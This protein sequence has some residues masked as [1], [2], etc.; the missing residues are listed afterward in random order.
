MQNYMKI[1]L[2]KIVKCLV[3]L[4]VLVNINILNEDKVSAE[5]SDINEVQLY[6]MYH[7]N[8]GDTLYLI[9]QKFDT[10][11]EEL[12]RVNH[13]K[14]SLLMVGQPLKIPNEKGRYYLVQPNDTLYLIAG[15][16]NLSVSQLKLVNKLTSNNIFVGQ[17][18]YIPDRETVAIIN[19][20]PIGLYKNGADNRNIQLVQQALNHYGYALSEDGIYGWRTT[21]AI[22]DFQSQ[23]GTLVN[24]GVYGPNTKKVLQQEILTDKYIVSNPNDTLVLVNKEYG[25]PK[26]YV[27]NNLVVP[28]VKFLFNEYHPKKL[29]RKVAAD[30][31]E[32]LF[33]QAQREGIQLFAV[34]GYRSFERQHWIFSSKAMD[35]GMWQANTLSAKAGESEHQ[36]GLT[37][38]VTSESAN[39]QLTQGFGGTREGKWLEKN[40]A[41]FGFIIHYL[42]GKEH[43]TGYEY[44]PWHIRYVG[45]RAAQQMMSN[46]ITLEEYL[47]KVGTIDTRQSC[48]IP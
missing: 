40:A 2:Q 10:S 33:N 32:L 19:Q 13:L 48:L 4:L 1:G 38:D 26:D 9:A 21:K 17:T 16:F 28:N 18:L 41:K 36:T 15:W 43:I 37:M 46:D 12:M 44:E 6:S 47:G 20:L 7:V 22:K 11:I 5:N 30:A 42:K 23:H 27:P 34:S 29:M 14:N 24:D 25:L 39:F 31:L 8:P 35:I 45:S 3:V